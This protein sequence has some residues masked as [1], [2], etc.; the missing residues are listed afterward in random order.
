[1]QQIIKMRVLAGLMSFGVISHPYAQNWI[2]TPQSYVGFNIQSSGVLLM[3]GKFNQFHANMYFHPELFQQAFMMLTMDVNSLYTSQ[4]SLKDKMMGKDYFHLEQH[5]TATFKSTQF[6]LL[7]QHKY[8][9]HGLLTLR[10]VTRP[11]IMKS[12]LKP[13]LSQPHLLDIEASTIINR[14]EFG[15]KPGIGGAG[16]K[17][18]F[19]ILGQWTT[20]K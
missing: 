14:T 3:A 11:V 16:E 6:K 9:I 12:S 10:G 17:I 20:I 5:K 18:N 8:H 19:F 13:N 1:M 7:G 4:L 2:L 15:M